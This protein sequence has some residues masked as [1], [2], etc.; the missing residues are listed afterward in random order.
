[1]TKTQLSL[2]PDMVPPKRLPSAK[3][4]HK[5]L[6]LDLSSTIPR[7][8]SPRGSQTE[9]ELVEFDGLL[10]EISKTETNG[11]IVETARTIDRDDPEIVSPTMRSQ[12]QLIKRGL[13]TR[14][15]LSKISEGERV[16]D[17]TG[18]VWKRLARHEL[19][20]SETGRRKLFA[21]IL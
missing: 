5:Q 4:E 1:M 16:T 2:F 15:Q 17:K 21:K 20:L 11:K 13:F 9:T 6:T 8:N 18:Q 19:P 14:Y 10:I 12:S 7:D 3:P